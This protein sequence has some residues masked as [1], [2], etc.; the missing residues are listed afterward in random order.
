MSIRVPLATFTTCLDIA[1][2][3]TDEH[4]YPRITRIQEECLA[5]A[6]R[7]HSLIRVHP[8]L[9]SVFIRVQMMAPSAV[10]P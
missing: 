5:S 7:N 4:E 8:L 9:L 6:K 1:R 3:D 2:L 10:T